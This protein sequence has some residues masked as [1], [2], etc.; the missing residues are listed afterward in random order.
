MSDRIKANKT[1]RRAKTAP[2]GIGLGAVLLSAGLAVSAGD[3]WPQAF[4]AKAIRIVVPFPPSGSVDVSARALQQP[5][6][7]AF[8]QSVVVD[9]RPGAS[10]MIG[11]E[12][13]ARAPPDGHTLLIAGFTFIA[14]AVMRSKLPFDAQKDFIGVARIGADPYIVCVHPSLPVRSVKDLVVLARARPGQ[15]TYATNGAGSSQ[16][17][18]GEMLK[19]SAGIDLVHVPY[20]GGGP[21]ALSVLGGHN[22]VLIA[23]IATAIAH[24]NAGRIR[25]LAVTSQARTPLVPDTPTLAE[26][27]YPEFE[28]TGKL[29][30]FARSAVPKDAIDRLGAEIVRALQLSEVKETLFKQGI[31]AA[32]LGPAQFDALIQ[33]EI[34]RIRKIVQAA[35]IRLD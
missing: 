4:P 34:P 8:G 27:G 32:P 26:S 30:V 5:L 20:Q 33:A 19:Q 17:V 35:G 23:T 18:T 14:N 29:G 7:K 15:L 3:A 6:S 22:P 25:A 9:N 1:T 24:L 16:H 13:V 12:L 2:A 21:S 31:D 28:L 11:T 10:T